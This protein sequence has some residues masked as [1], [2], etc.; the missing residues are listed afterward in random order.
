MSYRSIPPPRDAFHQA[1][2]F[3]RRNIGHPT[4][5]VWI[6]MR[7]ARRRFVSFEEIEGRI[8][9]WYCNKYSYPYQ[10]LRQH[11]IERQ[12]SGWRQLGGVI[13]ERNWTEMFE[14]ANK[15]TGFRALY[16]LID[17]NGKPV[18]SQRCK[19]CNAGINPV[20]GGHVKRRR[21]CRSPVCH[22]LER[23]QF[24]R[25]MKK[26]FISLLHSV[27]WELKS[28]VCVCWYLAVIARGQKRKAA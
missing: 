10:Y 6:V 11:G 13:G 9:T 15:K 26:D 19:W 27:E 17:E 2:I 24:M 1:H 8:A 3:W 21:T 25:Y 20:F 14:H 18:Y 7:I 28:L 4:W 5:F 22:D 16:C 23:R 12:L